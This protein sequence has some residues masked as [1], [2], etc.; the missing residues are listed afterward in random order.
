MKHHIRN[1]CR[2]AMANYH[3]ISIISLFLTV[4]ACKQ[5]VY[6]L[7]I[8]HIDYSIRLYY[9]LP[10]C[11]IKKV[12]VQSISAKLILVRN[13]FDSVSKCLKELHWIPV[14]LRIQFQILTIV[15]KCLK[16]QAPP[17]LTDLLYTDTNR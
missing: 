3:S 7:I 1:K 11:D 10:K 17:C 2:N 12:H 16:D 6:G 14:A 5:K 15:W 8:P 4:K 13:K 9:C